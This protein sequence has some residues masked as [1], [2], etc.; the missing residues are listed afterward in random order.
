MKEKDT[1]YEKYQ[2][3]RNNRNRAA[4]AER[5]AEKASGRTSTRN[6]A[7][8]SDIL[9]AWGFTQASFARAVSTTKQNIGHYFLR[10]DAPLSAIQRHLAGIRIRLKVS[11]DGV[12]DG[13][14]A[15]Y[16]II[17]DD[18]ALPPL[19]GQP[20][21]VSL[22]LD[23]FNQPSRTTFLAR[24]IVLKG[25]PVECFCSYVGLKV[26]RLRTI[27]QSDDI[28]ISEIYRIGKAFGLKISWIAEAIK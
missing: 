21:L 11:Y 19:Y 12:S 20:S 17:W 18:R 3:N 1:Q 10:D 27:L 5:K 24:L 8:L 25:L 26:S 23:R 13:Q 22:V 28:R 9:R 4:R 16:Q 2:N 14:G 15:H 6:L 7:F